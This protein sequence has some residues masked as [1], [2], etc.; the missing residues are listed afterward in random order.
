M[1]GAE[2]CARV[3]GNRLPVGQYCCSGDGYEK[4]Y[5]C[6]HTVVE[7]DVLQQQSEG[8]REMI[9]CNN[10]SIIFNYLTGGGRGELSGQ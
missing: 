10:F 1:K 2:L 3:V 5:D 9:F 8:K 6:Y 4:A 7:F